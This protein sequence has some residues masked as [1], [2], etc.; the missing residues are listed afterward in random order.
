MNDITV[1][2][3]SS[4]DQEIIINQIPNWTKLVLNQIDIR[5]SH[6]DVLIVD[7]KEGEYYNMVFRKRPDPTNV[8]SFPENNNSGLIV[9]CDAV[10]QKESMELDRTVEE[11]Y[12]QVYS[13]GVL[14]LCGYTHDFDEDT[15]I[16]ESIE[17]NLFEMFKKNKS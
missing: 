13:H 12:F 15:Q 6:I 10:I 3:Q 8:L 5:S 11:R 7:V 1:D 17:D 4:I 9:L 16:M 14:H 2:I